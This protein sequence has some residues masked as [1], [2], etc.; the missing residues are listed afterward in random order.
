MAY[1]KEAHPESFLFEALDFYNRYQ[2]VMDAAALK[3][4]NVYYLRGMEGVIVYN[5]VKRTLSTDASASAS[6][7]YSIPLASI[8]G[9]GSGDQ[10][11]QAANSANLF[12][13]LIRQSN[14]DQLPN[15]NT[16]LTGLNKI[17]K[18]LISYSNANAKQA[19]YDA[20]SKS[21]KASFVMV[22]L[23]SSLCSRS[24]WTVT[25]SNPSDIVLSSEFRSSAD[26]VKAAAASTS[27]PTGT[28]TNNPPSVCI[29]T[30]STN[31]ATGVDG[32]YITGTLLFNLDTAV[33]NSESEVLKG[34]TFKFSYKIDLPVLNLM[35]PV[36]AKNTTVDFWYQ[37]SDPTLLK[38]TIAA[39]LTHPKTIACGGTTID[40]P[41]ATIAT[42][43]SYTAPNS[44]PTVTGT[45]YHVQ[46]QWT[47]PTNVTT[48][49]IPGGSVNV[50][51]QS[52][53]PASISLPTT[54]GS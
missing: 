7:S 28:T 39:T 49:C 50:I 44:G 24:L 14:W 25:S 35:T 37:V 40:S 18:N 13:A 11:Y 36:A 3:S 43:T 8:S 20:T 52:G 48:T 6:A 26:Q 22:E 17:G 31:K 45:F 10:N 29:W 15:L 47:A 42:A 41:T 53:A 12:H 2:D 4:A 19:T 32:E 27:T 23:P 46:Y 9:S 16:T 51:T 34:I 21:V 5:T 38:T 30:V 54:T 33:N 1:L